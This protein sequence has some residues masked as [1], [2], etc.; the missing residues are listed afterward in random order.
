MAPQKKKSESFHFLHMEYEE[1]IIN[2][3]HDHHSLS[4]LLSALEDKVPWIHRG[5]QWP[6]VLAKTILQR[7]RPKR[8]NSRR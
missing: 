1:S 8:I 6:V 7:M 2:L 4:C 5:K 3:E